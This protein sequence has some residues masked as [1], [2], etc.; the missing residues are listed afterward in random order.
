MIFEGTLE[1]LGPAGRIVVA[2]RGSC[3]RVN[4]EWR[5]LPWVLRRVRL[6]SPALRFV[7]VRTDIF[8]REVW[9]A[10]V[11]PGG[12]GPGAHRGKLVLFPRLFGYTN[13]W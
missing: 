11:L 8:C 12:A 2:G 10:T 1:I 7:P 13:E 5:F 9:I 6:L 4:A 3:V